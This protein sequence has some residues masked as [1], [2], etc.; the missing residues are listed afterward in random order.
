[1]LTLATNAGEID[2]DARKSIRR[3][4]ASQRAAPAG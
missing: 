1:M 4:A 2:A 3:S